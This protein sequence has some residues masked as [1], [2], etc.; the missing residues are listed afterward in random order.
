MTPDLAEKY[1]VPDAD[2]I[3]DEDEADK[4]THR[5]AQVWLDAVEEYGDV[6]YQ[7]EALDYATWTDE[8]AGAMS[9]ILAAD[10]IDLDDVSV[11][12]DPDF[13]RVDAFL[14]A[15]VDRLD[16]HGGDLDALANDLGLETES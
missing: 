11:E 10:G 3:P 8:I 6:E 13:D 2:E 14:A 1:G 5:K 15:L 12:H 9:E 4:K 16:E 7:A